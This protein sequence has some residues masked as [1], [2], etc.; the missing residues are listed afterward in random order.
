MS[1]ITEYISILLAFL[2]FLL[3]WVMYRKTKEKL[4]I[5]C[6][7]I[8]DKKLMDKFCVH[9]KLVNIS[10]AKISIDINKSYFVTWN[11]K[12]NNLTPYKFTFYDPYSNE[13]TSLLNVNSTISSMVKI[14]KDELLHKL[15]LTTCDNNTFKLG[16]KKIINI[17]R[18]LCDN[19]PLIYQQY[20]AFLKRNFSEQ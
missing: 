10:N 12:N 6:K 5:D 4:Q 20:E 9:T 1:N 18:Q 17:N 8:P 11:C 15:A 2:S 14:S 7:V 16:S 3:A 19:L 13:R